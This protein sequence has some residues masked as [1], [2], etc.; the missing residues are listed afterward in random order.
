MAFE[1]SQLLTLRA[2]AERFWQDARFNNQYTAQVEGLK[3][4]MQNQTASFTEL[5]DSG[6]K[7]KIGITWINP[8]AIAVQDC[9]TDCTI[10]GQE[11][12]T[13]IKEYDILGCKE[14]TFSINET[15][16]ESNDYG[17]EEVYAKSEAQALKVLDEYLA[18]QSLI[19]LA[20]YKALNIAPAPF[21]NDD[22]L[23]TTEVP[24][25]QFRL[26]YLTA[27]LYQQAQ[28]NQFAN[29]YFINNGNLA[30]DYLNAQL[31]KSN[32]DGSGDFNRSNLLNMTFDY[33]NFL[34]A[35]VTDS[36][37]VVDSSAV[38]FVT[39]AKNPK[40]PTRK[41]NTI[42][43]QIPSKALAGVFYDVFYQ[44]ICIENEG[45]TEYKHSWKFKAR[46]DLFLNPEP[47][48]ITLGGVT[49]TPTGV[50]SYS[51]EDTAG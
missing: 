24:E 43:Y 22:A 23:K 49:V 33:V 5:K 9:T 20:T 32:A 38:A 45:E 50:Y 14:V 34:K 15:I 7:N 11:V 42:N 6:K 27:H 41:V 2:K 1:A 26:N 40:V 13:E 16:L 29:P 18:Q 48:P 3:A 17:L 37:F 36:L 35:S 12:D 46:W 28:L 44:E 8:C 39:K 30:I 25:A 31:D 51:I 47:C 21:T 10:T 19:K 4:I